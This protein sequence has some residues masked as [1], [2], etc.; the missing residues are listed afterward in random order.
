MNRE[1]KMN[2]V[3]KALKI[4]LVI[5][6]LLAAVLILPV[7]GKGFAAKAA[8]EAAA[9]DPEAAVEVMEYEQWQT[10]AYKAMVLAG[11][12]FLVL[13]FAYLTP[14]LIKAGKG[15][16]GIMDSEKAKKELAKY[17]PAGEALQA[18]VYADGLQTKT[19]HMFGKCEVIDDELVPNETIDAFFVQKAKCATHGL[20]IGITEHSLL[21]TECEENKHAYSYGP[22]EMT[23]EE[24]ANYGIEPITRRIPLREIGT[25]AFPLAAIEKCQMKNTAL[26]CVKC[27]VDFCDGSLLK[28]QINNGAGYGMPEH[29]ENRDKLVARLSEI[30]GMDA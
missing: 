10:D 26:G 9:A 21:F 11:V 17:L 18:V 13:A 16:F 22:L 27:T 2:K 5:C 6:L 23:A 8:R 30:K 19:N 3:K 7:L 15:D 12:F 14:A 25:H 29:K 1:E 4:R 28:F 20:Y 24:Y